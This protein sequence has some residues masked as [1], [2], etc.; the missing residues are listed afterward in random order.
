MQELNQ[1]TNRFLVQVVT[2]TRFDYFARVGLDEKLPAIQMSQNIL[3]AAQCFGEGQGV[4]IEEVVALSLELGVLL[5]L[6]DKDYVSSEGIRL[7][8][9]SKQL[10]M[11]QVPTPRVS[12]VL[13]F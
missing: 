2:L 6:E 5:L 11:E 1:T 12:F 8:N 10:V 7:H 3:E 13:K 9:T 4:L